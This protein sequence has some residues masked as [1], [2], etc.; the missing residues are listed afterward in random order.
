[1]RNIR[2][3]QSLAQASLKF[4]NNVVSKPLCG[5]HLLLPSYLATISFFLTK[6]LLLPHAVK[7]VPRP[8]SEKVLDIIVQLSPAE[9]DVAFFPREL[10]TCFLQGFHSGIRR[11]A[12]IIT[13]SIIISQLL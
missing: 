3:S 8:G 1:M 2:K 12:S 10:S 4:E 5:V 13:T 9:S 7:L 11:Q 6:I